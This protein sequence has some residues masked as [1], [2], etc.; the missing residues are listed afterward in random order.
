MVGTQY[1]AP[2]GHKSGDVVLTT[3]GIKMSVHDFELTG[4]GIVFDV[5]YI[6]NASFLSMGMKIFQLMEAPYLLETSY[7]SSVPLVE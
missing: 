6:A 2:A 7:R 1:G 3:N 4:G 5:A